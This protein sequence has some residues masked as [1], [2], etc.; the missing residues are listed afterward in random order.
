MTAEGLTCFQA[1]GRKLEQIR[2]LFWAE[3][4]YSCTAVSDNFFAL[5]K[6]VS[7]AKMECFLFGH[8]VLQVLFWAS[9]SYPQY[10]EIHPSR[11]VAA[12]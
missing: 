7:E 10:L 9:V 2:F 3:N 8:H 12:K 4:F 5:V 6:P 1:Q 11:D